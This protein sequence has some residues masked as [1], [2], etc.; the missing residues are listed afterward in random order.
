MSIATEIERLQTAKDDIKQAIEAKGV[1][2]PSGATI[3]TYDGY[4]DNISRGISLPQN[5]KSIVL[6]DDGRPEEIE[7]SD[8]LTAITESMYEGERTLTSIDI[9]S[10]VTEIGAYAFQ[11]CYALSSVTMPD[12]LETIGGYAFQSCSALA[13]IDI[14]SGVTDISQSV[15][16]NCSSLTSIDIPSG[17]TDISQNVF[18]NCSSLSSAT[19]HGDIENIGNSAFSKCAALTGITLPDS[20]LTIGSSTFL[21]CYALTSVVIPTGVTSIGTSAFENCSYMELVDMHSYTATGRYSFRNIGTNTPSGATL[22]LRGDDGIIDGSIYAYSFTNAFLKEMYV[23]D[24]LLA[25][26]RDDANWVNAVGNDTNNIKP[27][28]DYVSA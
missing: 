4:I 10:G 3:D 8:N 11:R 22:V 27:L 19:I 24:V 13:S 26:Y 25:N 12:D 17:V 21:Q 28:S 20:L 1:S 5:V 15:F 14:P 18:A 6:N 9:P 2:V 23:S 16:A 7:L